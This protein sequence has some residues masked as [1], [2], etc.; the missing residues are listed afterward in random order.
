MATCQTSGKIIHASR[1][2]ALAAIRALA[3]SG[4]GSPDYAAYRCPFGDH[5]H[6]GHDRNKFVRRIRRAMRGRADR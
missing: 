3:R 2:D 6:V 1:R 4:R 5:W